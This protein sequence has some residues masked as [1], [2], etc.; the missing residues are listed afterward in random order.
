M[1]NEETLVTGLKNKSYQMIM[2]SLA[3]SGR[4]DESF[5]SFVV[6]CVIEECAM[7]FKK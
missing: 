3:I 5:C 1:A 4:T 7:G 2:V 6:L